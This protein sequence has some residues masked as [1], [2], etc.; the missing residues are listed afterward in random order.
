MKENKFVFSDII[1]THWHHDHIGGVESILNLEGNK[2][3]SCNLSHIIDEQ[4]FTIIYL[5]LAILFIALLICFS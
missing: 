4:Y 5:A 1:L 3:K 2:G